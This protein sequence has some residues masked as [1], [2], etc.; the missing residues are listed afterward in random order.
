MAP[1]VIAGAIVALALVFG[2]LLEQ[3]VLA[4][5]AFR[6]SEV[7]ERLVVAEEKYEKLMH[8]AVLLDNPARIERIARQRLGM[9]EPDPAMQKF[10]VARIEMREGGPRLARLHDLSAPPDAAAAAT[11]VPDGASP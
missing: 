8:E 4:Q 7:R 6:L 3:I 9:V 5:S 11:G 1:R 2:V 10:V